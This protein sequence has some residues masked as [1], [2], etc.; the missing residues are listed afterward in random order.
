LQLQLQLQSFIIIIISLIIFN[1]IHYFISIIRQTNY[2]DRYNTVRSQ[3]NKCE[4]TQFI[5]IIINF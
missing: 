3:P 4:K 2:S 1:I 5:R